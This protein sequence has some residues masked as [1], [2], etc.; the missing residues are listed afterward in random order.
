MDDNISPSEVSTPAAA[1]RNGKRAAPTWIQN[2]P[3]AQL[4]GG[5]G[6]AKNIWELSKAGCSFH[7]F[8]Y[9]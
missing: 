2:D 3:K 4:P 6:V 5:P 7:P 1:F 8:N 9:S